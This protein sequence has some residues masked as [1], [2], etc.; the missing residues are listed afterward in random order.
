M[1]K[2][3]IETH[4][5]H[6]YGPQ[7]PAVNVKVYC[8]TP[9]YE[10]VMEKF[11]GCDKDTAE[12]ALEYAYEFSV[13]DFWER[14][15]EKAE[16]IF[17]NVK[18]H[19]AGRSSGWL[20]LNGLDPIESW[21]A[22]ACSKWFKFEKELKE[23]IKWRCSLEVVLEDIESNDWH[24]PYSEKY[25]FIEKKDGTSMCIADLKKEAIDAGYGD[26]VRR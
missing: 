17:G 25:N 1:K 11:P 12:K 20:V 16:E 18:V 24:K 6:M 13:E 26:V 22:I 4:S 9:G 14:A 8:R 21:D 19:S 15:K 7:Y 23:E 5:D 2:S 3:D 10:D